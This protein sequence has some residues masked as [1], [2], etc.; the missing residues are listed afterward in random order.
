MVSIVIVN[1]KV[2]DL[3]HACLKSVYR[4]SSVTTE[5][6]VIDNDSKD[7]TGEMLAREFPEVKFIGNNFNA[8]FPA[9]N[10][11]ALKQCTGE[12]ILLLNPDTELI[13][14]AIPELV[15]FSKT[16]NNNCII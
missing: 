12:Y 10:N 13:H 2:K 4:F 6:W 3:L 8:G 5:V 16:K 15:S 11:Q 14:D 1:Y 7:G 9:A